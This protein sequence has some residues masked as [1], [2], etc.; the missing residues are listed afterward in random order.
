[1]TVASYQLLRAD[2]RKIAPYKPAPSNPDASVVAALKVMLRDHQ[3]P[4]AHSLLFVMDDGSRV[5]AKPRNP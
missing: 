1:M 3:T 2:G 4:H 5:I